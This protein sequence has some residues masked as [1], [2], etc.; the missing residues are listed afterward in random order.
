VIFGVPQWE[1][2]VGWSVGE[3]GAEGI[4]GPKRVEVTGG[5]KPA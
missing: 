5:E 4:F 1:K 2:N 3:N